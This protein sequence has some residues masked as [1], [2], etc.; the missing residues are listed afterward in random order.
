MCTYNL[1]NTQS[2]PRDVSNDYDKRSSTLMLRPGRLRCNHFLNS[3]DL[4]TLPVNLSLTRMHKTIYDFTLDI[5]STY[6]YSQIL[7]INIYNVFLI[8]ACVSTGHGTSKVSHIQLCRR[9][10]R[11]TMV[12]EMSCNSTFSLSCNNMSVVKRC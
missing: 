2:C 11:Y 9:L 6:I 3:D 10:L 5:P 7:G 1:M 4:Q 8:P 12:L